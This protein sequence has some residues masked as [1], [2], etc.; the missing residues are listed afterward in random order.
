MKAGW[1]LGVTSMFQWFNGRKLT[2]LYSALTVMCTWWSIRL[3]GSAPWNFHSGWDSSNKA[4]ISR[5]WEKWK[6]VKCS[7]LKDFDHFSDHSSYIF[8][9]TTE[10][11]FLF[12]VL[13]GITD[14]ESLLLKQYQGLFYHWIG[15]GLI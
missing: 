10:N 1:V 6:C 3:K 12:M 13:C 7:A 9:T 14:N 15:I 2:L 4:K 8:K 11:R 5:N